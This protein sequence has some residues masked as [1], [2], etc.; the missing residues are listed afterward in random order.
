MASESL[1]TRL[2]HA[3]YLEPLDYFL[4]SSQIHIY[5]HGYLVGHVGAQGDS[6]LTFASF[7]S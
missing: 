7:L 4:L 6:S 3:M 5:K 1:A 2:L